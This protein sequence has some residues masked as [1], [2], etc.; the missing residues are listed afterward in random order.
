MTAIASL[1]A[2]PLTPAVLRCARHFKQWWHSG[3][4]EA[5]RGRVGPAIVG[6]RFG[7]AILGGA[8]ASP[9]A[10]GYYP[11]P[12]YYGGRY[13]HDGGP[14]YYAPRPAYSC[15]RRACDGFRYVRVYVC[16]FDANGSAKCLD[17]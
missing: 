1:T 11:G 3:T 8:L 5:R 10:Y 9:Y 15:W 17:P 13:P 16:W 6:G 7:A 4:A 2:P 12:A 14:V